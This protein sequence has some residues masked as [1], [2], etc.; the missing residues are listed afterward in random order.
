[1]II[2]AL[3]YLLRSS[4]RALRLVRLI[5]DLVLWAESLSLLNEWVCTYEFRRRSGELRRKTT[6]RDGAHSPT[7]LRVEE[8]VALSSFEGL[9]RISSSRFHRAWALAHPARGLYDEQILFSLLCF[10]GL[11]IGTLA[12]SAGGDEQSLM[13]TIIALSPIAFCI[14]QFVTMMRIQTVKQLGSLSALSFFSALVVVA[15]TLMTYFVL[16]FAGL[17]A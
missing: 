10:A 5:R 17:S 12:V 1:M 3:S 7:G 13:V 2:V 16:A 11:A 14:A 8:S 6:K 9:T 15:A 4:G